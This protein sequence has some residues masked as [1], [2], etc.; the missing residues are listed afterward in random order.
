MR[1]ALLLC[2]AALLAAGFTRNAPPACGDAAL[3]AAPDEWDAATAVTGDLTMD[4]NEDVVFWKTEDGAVML[5]IA[6]CEGDR[7]VE[8]WR[9]RIPFAED[10]PPS[11][12][13][14]AVA[15]LLIDAELVE[16]VCGSGNSEECQHMRMENERRKALTDAGGRQLRIGGA[17]CAG[18]RLRWSTAG[19]GFMRIGG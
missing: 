14:V 13:V 15:S 8:T 5:Y 10:C 19:G 18:T 7:A 11:G 1:S 17:A 2:L 3:D 12:A 6:A 4:G 9:Y 16:R